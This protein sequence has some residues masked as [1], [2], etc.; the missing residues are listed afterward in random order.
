MGVPFFT[1]HSFVLLKC[2]AHLM[3]RHA[4]NRLQGLSELFFFPLRCLHE[5]SWSHGNSHFYACMMM[6]CS[7]TLWMIFIHKAWHD[8]TFSSHVCFG[9]VKTWCKVNV[10]CGVALCNHISMNLLDKHMGH[11]CRAFCHGKFLCGL[12]KIV[13]EE[14]TASGWDFFCISPG[15][16]FHSWWPMPVELER[17]MWWQMLCTYYLSSVSTVDKF[18][19][20][21]ARSCIVRKEVIFCQLWWGWDH[22][23]PDNDILHIHHQE[24]EIRLWLHSFAAKRVI[25]L[26]Q[27]IS[28]TGWGVSHPMYRKEKQK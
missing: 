9:L 14:W 25:R 3:Y 15:F 7:V 28:G 10:F 24:I 22:S 23:K 18:P 8:N 27:D 19:R 2:M 16:M 6:G 26:R 20:D 12:N 17:F 11:A 4:D 5:V 1:V 13:Y 21:L